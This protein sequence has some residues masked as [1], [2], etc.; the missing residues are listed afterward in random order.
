MHF[1]APSRHA[2]LSVT[3]ASLLV[4]SAPSV[5]GT[6]GVASGSARALPAVPVFHLR[7][8]KSDPAD[9]ATLSSP[10]KVIRLW[11]S[12]PPELAVTTI[13]LADAK[14]NPVTLA[15]PQRGAGAKD[16]VEGAVQGTLADGVYS[17]AWKTSSKDGHPI[18]GSF[19]FT[20]KG[21]GR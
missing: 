3:I 20:V 11:F 6:R 9:G 17:V 18:K 2:V 7:L 15:A 4:I 5:G 14:G 19:S 16:P 13:K 8:E 12:L 21:G 10:P 1:W